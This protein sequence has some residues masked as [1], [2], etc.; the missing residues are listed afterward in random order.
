MENFSF[1]SF[2]T[3]L[4]LAAVILFGGLWAARQLR[5]L[6]N[7]LLNKRG[8][9]PMLSSFAASIAHILLIA[10]VVIASLGQLG[11]QT[12]SLVA[13]IGAAGLAIG[14]ALQGSLANFASGVMIIAFRPFKV[15]DF[16]DAGGTSGVVEGIQIF[17][18]QLRTGDNKTIIIPNSKITGGS[19]TNFSAKETRRVDLVFGISYDDDIRMAKEILKDIVAADERILKDPA[20]VIAVSEL[21]DSSVKF[22]VRPWVKSADYWAVYF[23]LTENVKLRFDNEGI[24]IPYPQRDVHMHQAA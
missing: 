9:D 8:V 20:P 17:S 1:M 7:N 23:D 24:S 14:L 10:F 18:T 4:A 16:I 5:N 12:T 2:I 15:G 21:A 22:V 6:V 3:N 11:I 13:I 19:I